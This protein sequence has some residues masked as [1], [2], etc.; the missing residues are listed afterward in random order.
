MTTTESSLTEQ[1]NAAPL[2]EGVW[3]GAR[4][5]GGGKAAFALYAP[6]KQS[7][8]LIGDF[9]DWDKT[10]DPLAVSEQGIWWIVKELGAGEHAYQFAV[11]GETI[12]GDP[13]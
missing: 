1:T 3:L 12:I 8:H 2:P 7:V 10:A 5:L 9:N 11:D 4:D 13:Y 6:W